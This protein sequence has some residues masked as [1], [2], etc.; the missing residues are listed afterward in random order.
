MKRLVPEDRMVLLSKAPDQGLLEVETAA[1]RAL[2]GTNTIAEHPAGSAVKLAKETLADPMIWFLVLTSAIFGAIGQ[3]TDMAVLLGA[4]APLVGM[5]LYL[6][7]RTQAS[8]EGLRSV[9][10][11][12]ARVVRNGGERQVEAAELVPG[13]LVRVAAGESFPADGLIV[14]GTSLQAENRH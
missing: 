6:H 10:T 8:I 11:T 1:L 7:R 14:S 9:L 12:S 5:D 2:Y 13:D 4:I 3:Y